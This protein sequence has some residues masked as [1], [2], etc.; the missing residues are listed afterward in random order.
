MKKLIIFLGIFLFAKTFY[1]NKGWNL[2]GTDVDINVSNLDVP[3]I[4][5]Y[6]NGK[7]FYYS[8]T[9]KLNYPKIDKIYK[10]DGF[11]IYTNKNII[12]TNKKI[13]ILPLYF[14]DLQK[15]EKVKNII[16][17]EIII[18]NP[19]NGPGNTVDKNYESLIK[20]L[21]NNKVPIGYITSS[22][23]HKNF[24]TLKKEIDKWINLYPDIKGFFIDEVSTDNYDYYQKIYEYIKKRNYLV[25]LNPGTK[26]NL[27]YF[28]IADII[29]VYEGENSK[30]SYYCNDFPQKSAIIIYNANETVMKKIINS[31][32]RYIFVS[33]EINNNY[34]KLPTY[35][36]EEIK[37]L[38]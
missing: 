32:C 37:L 12:F 38:K 21:S 9:Y 6:N 16:N 14:Y 34:S 31:K 5:K 7:W 24:N 2:L 25:I 35:F 23:A 26:V 10:N 8:K 11:W 28:N 3:I 18:I 19:S 22:Y 15:W 17:D 29:V 36:D 27:N 4:W 1:V 30:F 33:D 20:S 13:L